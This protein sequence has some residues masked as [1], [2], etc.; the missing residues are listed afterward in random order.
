[1]TTTLTPEEQLR[2]IELDFQ[3]YLNADTQLAIRATY[4]KPLVERIRIVLKE[5]TGGVLPASQADELKEQLDEAK[6]DLKHYETKYEKSR[7][8]VEELEAKIKRME[9]ALK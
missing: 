5:F 9:A 2:E 6:A 8:E 7:E 4:D 3:K 1:M